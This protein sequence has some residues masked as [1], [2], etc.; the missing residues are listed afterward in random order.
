M[1]STGPALPTVVR[2]AQSLAERLN[3]SPVGPAARALVSKSRTVSWQ[4]AGCP[5]PAPPHR[6]QRIVVEH[7]KHFQ[8]ATFVE[9]GTYRGD[10]IAAVRTHVA[11]SISIELDETLCALARQRFHRHPDVEILWGDSGTLLADVVEKLTEPAVFW[12]DGHYSG[13]ATAD[14][15]GDAPILNEL[16]AV[17]MSSVPHLV[18][19]DDARLFDGTNG[20]PTLEIVAALVAAHRPGTSVTTEN[21]IVVCHP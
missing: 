21:D 1:S 13:G 16:E 19:I 6:K 20:Y 10:T 14:S 15:G 11:K 18:L 5:A 17:L 4:R 2:P 3:R 9:T 7:V 8:P 12:L